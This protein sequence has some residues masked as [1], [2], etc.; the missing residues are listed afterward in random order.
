MIPNL[1]LQIQMISPMNFN[2]SKLDIIE[3]VD[4]YKVTLNSCLIF[5]DFHGIIFIILMIIQYIK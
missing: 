3:A 5:D 2:F 1:H 4:K